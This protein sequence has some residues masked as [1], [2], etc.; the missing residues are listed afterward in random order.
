MTFARFRKD[1][2][3]WDIAL[4][5]VLLNVFLQLGC[6]MGTATGADGLSL[7]DPLSWCSIDKTDASA[8][9]QADSGD[10]HTADCSDCRQCTGQAAVVATSMD[11]VV[12]AA[13]PND[14]VSITPVIAPTLSLTV[15]PYEGRGPPQTLRT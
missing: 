6:C 3:A 7:S 2:A 12:L 5:A 14:P 4:V 10:S 9:G 13:V 8:Q 1:S 11:R 15:V